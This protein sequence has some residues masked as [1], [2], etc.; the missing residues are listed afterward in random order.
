MKRTSW[1]TGRA[2]RVADLGPCRVYGGAFAPLYTVSRLAACPTRLPASPASPYL[3]AVFGQKSAQIAVA[4]RRL[5]VTADGQFGP[6][7]FAK[8]VSWQAR[9]HVPVTGVL[10]KATWHSLV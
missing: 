10:D 4:Q 6:A 2:V 5:G 1:W 3:V 7:T 9:A 8:V